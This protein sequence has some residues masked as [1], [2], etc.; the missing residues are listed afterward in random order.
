VVGEAP[1][2]QPVLSIV[3]PYYR[4]PTMLTEQYRIWSGYP[5]DLRQ[6]I[7]VLIVDDGSPEPERAIKV[8]APPSALMPYT[9]I[10]EVLEDRPWHQ[11]GAR[12]LGAKE[13]NGGWLFLTDM[14]HAISGASLREL[15]QRCNIEVVYTFARINAS[16][17][18]PKLTPNG[19]S[20]P[21]PNIYAMPKA[22]FWQAGGYD[23]DCTGYGTDSFFRRRLEHYT[24]FVHL[25]HVP[26]V[27]YGRDVI[28]DAST[29]TL[30]RKEGRPVGHKR[31]LRNM[32]AAKTARGEKP[33]TL[34]FPWRR[35]R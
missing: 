23:E 30:P 6:Q 15:L 5:P 1:V 26:I 4:N 20:H 9:R 10:Y 8:E 31:E 27:R 34:D 35:V 21:H 32:I 24:P 29:T 28:P 17:G 25:R 2:N 7:E 16:D 12:N 19:E 33:K 3:V 14:D 18:Q 13:A 22:L 11:H